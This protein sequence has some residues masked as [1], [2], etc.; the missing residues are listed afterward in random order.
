MTDKELQMLVSSYR[1]APYFDYIFGTNHEYSSKE[2]HFSKL[3]SNNQMDFG[4]FIGDGLEDMKIAKKYNFFAIG[5][6][7]N[8]EEEA[9]FD[10][11]ADSV[12]TYAQLSSELE[13]LIAENSVK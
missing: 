4:V 3:L 7:V 5:L 12:C 1:L 9:L 10:A 11:G 2:D 13:I 8:H 6:P